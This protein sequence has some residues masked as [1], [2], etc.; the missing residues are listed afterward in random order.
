MQIETVGFQ[1]VPAFSEDP[2]SCGVLGHLRTLTSDGG[3]GTLSAA[4]DRLGGGAND[5]VDLSSRKYSHLRVCPKDQCTWLQMKTRSH[6]DTKQSK[7][8]KDE[9]K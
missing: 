8:R 1:T 2:L 5:D 6:N 4:L 3:I 9:I 7:A